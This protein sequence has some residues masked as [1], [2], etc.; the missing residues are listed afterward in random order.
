M[1]DCEWMPRHLV[2][3]EK[4]ISIDDFSKEH[5]MRFSIEVNIV[6]IVD[7]AISKMAASKYSQ[8]NDL[9]PKNGDFY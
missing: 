8:Q 5:M 2:T 7:N 4:P 3:V 6:K 9:Y 1:S